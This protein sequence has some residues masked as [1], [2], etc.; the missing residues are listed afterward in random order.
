VIAPLT[1]IRLVAATWVVLFH[2]YLV[3]GDR[4]GSAHPV[5]DAVVGPVV[6]QGDLGVDLFFLLSGFVL[7]HNYLE[8][9]GGAPSVRQTVSFLWLRLSRIWPLYMVA[10]LGGGLLLWLR[11]E[12][13]G[14][15]P[16]APL[17]WGRFASQALMVQ[18][19]SAPNVPDTSWSGPAWSISAEW[20]AYLAF[21]VLAIVIWHLRRLAGHASTALL[22]AGVLVPTLVW[23]T[24]AQTQAAPYMWLARL[25]AEF[26]CGMLLS[27]TISSAAPGALTAVRRAASTWLAS[28]TVIATL[29]WLYVAELVGRPWIGPLVVALFP[30]LVLALALGDGPMHRW[31]GSSPMVVGGGVSFA[32]YLVHVPLLKLFRDA[33]EHGV[34]PLDADHQVYGELV[35]AV[36]CGAL[37]YLLFRRVEEPARRRLRAVGPRATGQVPAVPDPARPSVQVSGP[38]VDSAAP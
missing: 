21:P 10:I 19:W 38:L 37:A 26:T 1:G 14:T 36:A 17:S 15:E 35:V 18:Q 20:L 32:L 9:L 29:V 11:L 28:A 4:L 6:S 33:R 2:I 30:A 23:T 12:W 13:W 8:R 24:T 34:V 5:V 22:A 25:A 27:A 31:L 3:N 16:N 7:A